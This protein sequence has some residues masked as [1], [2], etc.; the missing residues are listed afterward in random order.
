MRGAGQEFPESES[1]WKT[2]RNRAAEVSAPLQLLI[3]FMCV[4]AR[5]GSVLVNGSMLALLED[6]LILD[7]L[8]SM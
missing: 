4:V 3:V 5:P 6:W 2:V 8:I 7:L 1:K